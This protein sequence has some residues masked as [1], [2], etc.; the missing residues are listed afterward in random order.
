MIGSQKVICALATE[1]SE[2]LVFL[3]ELVEAGKIKSVIDRCYPL[4]Q[5][6][7]AHR[8]YESGQK[9]GNVVITIGP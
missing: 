9:R 6:A 2:D 8:Y 7:E 5:A 1:K 4:E 3:K